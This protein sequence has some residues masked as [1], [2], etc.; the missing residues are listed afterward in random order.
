MSL[1]ATL[2]TILT[3][4]AAVS[5][6][7]GTRVYPAQVEKP[8]VPY[9]TYEVRGGE[10]TFTRSGYTGLESRTVTINCIAHVYDDAVSLANAVKA[11]IPLWGGNW[12]GT[13]VRMIRRDDERDYYTAAEGTVTP[14]GRQLDFTARYAA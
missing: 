7:V 11:A 12:A 9:V 10:D 2:F 3:S 8:T 13:D 1:E 5:A 6:I 14:I 4:D